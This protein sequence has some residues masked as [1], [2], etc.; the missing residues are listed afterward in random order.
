VIS[1]L[2]KVLQNILYT[3][4]IMNID[5]K[6]KS[7][8]YYFGSFSVISMLL[9]HLLFISNLF[10]QDNKNSLKILWQKDFETEP[11][12]NFSPGAICYD[13]IEHRI[14]L[15]G[16]SYR[17]NKE[18]NLTERSFFLCQMKEDGSK[19]KSLFLD[20]IQGGAAQLDT[21]TLFIKGL[22]IFPN[23]DILSIGPFK[24]YQL[25]IIK[26][27]RK[28]SDVT[29]IP[30][31]SEN[32]KE[33]DIEIYK[34]I[35]LEDDILIIGLIGG[36]SPF[37]NGLIARITTDGKVIWKKKFNY[38]KNVFF[39]D[40]AINEIN[41]TFIVAGY[42]LPKE[43]KDFFTYKPEIWILLCDFEGNIISEKIFPG[44]IPKICCLSS[45]QYIILYDRTNELVTENLSLKSLGEN[46]TE[47]WEKHLLTRDIFPIQFMI[48]PLNN[49][50]FIAAAYTKIDSI[51]FYEFDEKGNQQG[52]LEIV[53]KKLLP[54]TLIF[55]CY[56]NKIFV[57][58]QLIGE[59][60][61]KN[62][63]ML[64]IEAIR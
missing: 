48:Q 36:G 11:N 24:S 21:P 63:K 41:R 7:S 56:N 40:V 3:G 47:L 44:R 33:K 52:Y 43:T 46:L 25:S 51:V 31:F 13:E 59:K 53:Q 37:A 61:N 42:S 50:H 12:V 49:N 10:S 27:T 19:I 22:E 58:F 28:L 20:K 62:I 1:K 2:L 57:C 34:M 18:N 45:K 14:F 9:I 16:T 55:R 64:G 32:L 5:R 8:K 54:G 29:L 60:G 39:T 4:V 38:G 35:R 23:G 30:L 15:L 6:K 26:S 17:Y